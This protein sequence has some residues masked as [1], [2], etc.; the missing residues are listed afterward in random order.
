MDTV[1]V[2]GDQLD[3]SLGALGDATPG[4]AR[5]VMVESAAKMASQPWHRQRAHLIVTAMRRFA[6]DLADEGFE[7][8]YRHA[9][10]LATGLAGHVAD[11]S[12]TRVLATEANSF[13]GQRMLDDLGV[14]SVASDH[15]LCHRND[16]AQ[17]AS[18]RKLLR[19]EDFY[20]FQRRRLGYLM[21]G[22]EPAGRPVELRHRQPGTPTHRWP[23]VA[24]PAGH[25]ARCHRPRRARWVAGNVLGG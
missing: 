10:T 11:Y 9:P 4:T 13:D 16:F 17:W 21:D 8:D 19:M 3:R 6:G 14:V 12:P 24:D 25:A 5:V 2:L 1:W 22:D 18:G 23:C 15:F 20:R 7:V